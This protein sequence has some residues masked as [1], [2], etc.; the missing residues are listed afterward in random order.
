MT[1]AYANRYEPEPSLDDFG[2]MAETAFATLPETV[3]IACGRVVF[4]I[5]DYAD[6]HA[7]SGHLPPPEVWLYRAAILN[8][9][10]SRG[11]V[12]LQDMVTHVLVH[13]IG[14]HMG[15]SDD[16]IDELESQAD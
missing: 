12:T 14:H 13:E 3:R 1:H 7:N 6:A 5:A 9:W 2:V 8:E 16:D 15:L 11:N 10:R 4:R